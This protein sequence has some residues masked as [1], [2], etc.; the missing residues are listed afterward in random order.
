MIG[1][2]FANIDVVLRRIR[3]RLRSDGQ[4][5]M[6]VGDS[7][8]AGITVPVAKILSEL[9]EAERFLH[10]V[11]NERFRSMRASIQQ[12]RN[13]ELGETLLVLQKR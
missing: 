7:R 2:Y 9:A 4:I 10:V 11:K 8:Y 1:G 12:G 13:E 6:V 3:T 5:W